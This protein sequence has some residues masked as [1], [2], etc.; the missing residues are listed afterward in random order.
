METNLA[1]LRLTGHMTPLVPEVV[2]SWGQPVVEDLVHGF[3]GGW[4]V[5][6]GCLLHGVTQ[7]RYHGDGGLGDRGMGVGPLCN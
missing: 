5:S 1:S 7:G 6:L 2:H 4:G 3:R